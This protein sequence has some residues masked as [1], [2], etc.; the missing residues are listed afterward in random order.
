MSLLNNFVDT[1]VQHAAKQSLMVDNLTE[2]APILASLPVQPSSHDISNVYEEILSV[3]GAEVSDMDDTI[4]GVRLDTK[5]QQQDLTLIKGLIEIGQ[6]KARRFGTPSAYFAHVIPAVLRATGANVEHSILYDI[7]K[8]AAIDNDN[9]VDIEG[10]T[11]NKQNTILAVRWSGG[12]SGLYSKQMYSSGK[13][14][15]M[16][17]VS[18][19]NVYMDSS[20]KAIYGLILAMSLGVQVADKRGI[21]AMVNVDVQAGTPKV[22]TALQIDELISSVRGDASNTMLYMHKS[23]YD[24]AIKPLITRTYQAVDNSVNRSFSNWDGVQIVTSYNFDLNAEAVVS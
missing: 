7:L 22:P 18:G 10:T 15:E 11:S 20:N 3:V 5:L 16:V 12:N 17:P 9:V 4:A 21:A 24:K 13:A 19:G 14:F 2:D 23:V 1:A 8:K 6:D